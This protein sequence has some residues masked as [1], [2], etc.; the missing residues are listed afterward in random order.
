MFAEPDWQGRPSHM[1][2]SM[3]ETRA[4]SKVLSL[5]YKDV[6]AMA[7]FEPTPAEEMTFRQER[8]RKTDHNV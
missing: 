3:A 6:M 1:V 8:T 2:C 5:L 4:V 7:G